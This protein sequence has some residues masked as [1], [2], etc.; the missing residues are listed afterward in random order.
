MKKR[1]IVITIIIICIMVIL[2]IYIYIDKQSYKKEMIRQAEINLKFKDDR[3]I[4]FLDEKK[5]SDYI[6]EID[7]KIVEDYNIDLKLWDK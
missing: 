4:E 1:I 2:G 5:V 6:E 7:G 3:T